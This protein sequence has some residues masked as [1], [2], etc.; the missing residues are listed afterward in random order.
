VNAHW[1]VTFPADLTE[2]ASVYNLD[3]ADSLF[4]WNGKELCARYGS[5]EY[6][7]TIYEGADAEDELGRIVSWLA[8]GSDPCAE[9]RA[10][11]IG[12]DE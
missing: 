9:R 1:Y 10:V 2:P 3:R 6:A 7:P 5:D 12:T 8:G 4:V 11:L